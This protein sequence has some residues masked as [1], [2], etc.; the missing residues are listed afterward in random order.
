VVGRQERP[1][2]SET[3]CVV[4]RAGARR[5]E[6][7][8]S[9]VSGYG[10]LWTWHTRPSVTTPIILVAEGEAGKES[11]PIRCP[12]R[13]GF[14]HFERALYAEQRRASEEGVVASGL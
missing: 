11:V 2:G 4:R 12:G 14:A 13:A 10:F 1:T 3:V 8:R 5:I 6:G 9:V 7:A